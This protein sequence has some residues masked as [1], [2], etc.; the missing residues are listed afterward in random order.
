MLVSCRNG[1]APGKASPEDTARSTNP[2]V[3]PPR[4]AASA[5]VN[6]PWTLRVYVA[7]ES[8]ERRNRFVAPPFQ[9][10]GLL[11]E[12]GG[13]EARN[14]TDEY[15]WMI[16]LA[17]RLRLRDPSLTLEW[18]GTDAWLAG[19]DNPYDGTYPST[20][21]GRTSA[22]SGTSIESWLE[23]R[24]GELERKT[25]CYDVA[26][27]A[28]GGNDFGLDD[29]AEYTRQLTLLVKLLARGSKCRATPMIYVTAHMPDFHDDVL[30]RALAELQ[31]KRFV[32]RTRSTVS[33]LAAQ[34]PTVRFIDSF[35]PFVENR[36]TTAFPKET[37]STGG[38]PDYSKIARTGDGLHP[39]RLA[40]IYVGEVAADALDLAELRQLFGR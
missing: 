22:I 11:N 2:Q 25:H 15:G 26:F 20:T 1:Q 40:S 13:G 17:A 16:P 33:A 27:A 12:R 6:A 21:P 31:R 9:P 18:V 37:W 35:T 24:K 23:Q 4:S 34:V 30:P 39:R 3:A 10:S 5:P 29:D 38:V 36:K 32:E 7:G 14:D 28:R 19:D 8:I